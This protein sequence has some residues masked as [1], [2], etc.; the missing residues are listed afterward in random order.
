MILFIGK[1][2]V[3]F[4]TFSICTFKNIQHKLEE[5]FDSRDTI[6]KELHLFLSSLDLLFMLLLCLSCSLIFLKLNPNLILIHLL[7][8]LKVLLIH[9][10]NLGVRLG[11]HFFLGKVHIVLFFQINTDKQISHIVFEDFLYFCPVISFHRH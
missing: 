10:A 3:L 1:L 11:F 5:N 6:H 4:L 8:F 2:L 7:S 9:L